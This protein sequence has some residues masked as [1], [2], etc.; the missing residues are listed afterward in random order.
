MIEVREG[1]VLQH[2][3][4]LIAVFAVDNWKYESYV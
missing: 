4:H 1:N 2:S 3:S